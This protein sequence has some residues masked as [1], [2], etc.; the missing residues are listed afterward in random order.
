MLKFRKLQCL[1]LGEN[2]KHLRSLHLQ[3]GKISLFNTDRTLEGNVNFF[4]CSYYLP[5]LERIAVSVLAISLG[6]YFIN[7][8]FPADS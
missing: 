1:F 4:S 6:A 7:H 8:A 5:V 3:T 2:M